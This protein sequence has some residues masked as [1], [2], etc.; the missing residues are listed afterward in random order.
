MKLDFPYKPSLICHC[1]LQL[2]KLD[3]LYMLFIWNKVSFLFWEIAGHKNID[4]Y[5]NNIILQK[6][7]LRGKGNF[8]NVKTTRITCKHKKNI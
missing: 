6:P 5:Y 4:L 8:K 3:K 1:K 2:V 7:K